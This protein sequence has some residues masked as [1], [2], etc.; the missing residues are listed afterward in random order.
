MHGTD[1]SGGASFNERAGGE[2]EDHD[3]IFD[4][5]T[6][7]IAAECIKIRAG[8]RLKFLIATNLAIKKVNLY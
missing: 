4:V 7:E 3:I 6:S 5:N 8:V 1:A 2:P